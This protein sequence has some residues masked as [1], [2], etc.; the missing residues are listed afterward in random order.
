MPCL[1]KLILVHRNHSVKRVRRESI[2]ELAGQ[3]PTPGAPA[4]RDPPC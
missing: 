1:Q 3:A 2:E 4:A